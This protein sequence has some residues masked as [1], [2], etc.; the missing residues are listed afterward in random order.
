[1][2]RKALAW[3][4]LLAI[5]SAV[6]IAAYE[7][8]A[9]QRHRASLV[10]RMEQIVLIGNHT[11]VPCA[12]VAAAHPFVLLAL[13]QSN[14]GNHGA[15]P[16]H[17]AEPVTLI[18]EGKCIR[19]TDPLPGGTGQ[20][21]SIWQRLS[22]L[23]STQ[24]EARPVALSV[25]AVDATSIADWTS[26]NSPLSARLASHV[27]SMRR[28]GLP[29]KFVLWQQ[30]EA[31]ALLGTSSEDYSIG[32][33]RL[34]TIL[35][36]AGVSAPILLARSTICQT[37]PNAAIRSAIE[38]RISSDLRFRLGPDMDTLSGNTFRNGCHLTASG[39]DSAAK[40]WAATISAEIPK[41]RHRD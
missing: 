10:A 28:L 14:A 2:T 16:S 19:A 40:M 13:G 37:K 30:G 18:A 22:A 38:G 3:L 23:L 4:S 17:A 33:G 25:L 7:F 36:E 32:L 20:G 9:H 21:G 6:A 12:E 26:P 31:D 35:S 5:A 27:V 39:L 11:E 29:P 24:K 15:L 41:I 1:M 34:A 8:I